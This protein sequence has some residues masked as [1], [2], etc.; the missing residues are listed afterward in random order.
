MNYRICKTSGENWGIVDEHQQCV[1]EGT[2]RQCEDWL[3][4]QENS[5]VPC[6][7]RF[8]DAVFQPV[9]RLL[10]L[11]RQPSNVRPSTRLQGCDEEAATR[12]R[13]TT[14]IDI[15]TQR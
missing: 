2:L 8:W 10:G 13:R 4:H 5:E 9:R 14:P 1:F 3:D 6:R 12:A 7:S 11:A 15:P